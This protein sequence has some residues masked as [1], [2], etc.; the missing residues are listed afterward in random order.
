MLSTSDILQF[1]AQLEKTVQ[2]SNNSLKTGARLLSN[3]YLNY[4]KEKEQNAD[5]KAG[6]FKSMFDSF[7]GKPGF[8]SQAIHLIREDLINGEEKQ[9]LELLKDPETNLIEA[10]EAMHAHYPT[11]ISTK[12]YEILLSNL[13]SGRAQLKSITKSSMV[14][15]SVIVQLLLE[16]DIEVIKEVLLHIVRL[17]DI[18]SLI[19]PFS[20]KNGRGFQQLYDFITKPKQ[21]DRQ[22]KRLAIRVL[23]RFKP[24]FA[25]NHIY[26][27][28]PKVAR[29]LF[30]TLESEDREFD[31]Q[32][33]QALALCSS[34]CF[35]KNDMSDLECMLIGADVSLFQRYYTLLC[36]VA[37]SR[38]RNQNYFPQTSYPTLLIA[39]ICDNNAYP[40]NNETNRVFLLNLFLTTLIGL[41]YKKMQ[42]KQIP[43][44]AFLCL[45][46]FCV[47]NLRPHE[48]P[49]FIQIISVM[50][51]Y[52]NDPNIFFE[53][54]TVAFLLGYLKSAKYDN[55][56]FIG[57]TAFLGHISK[58]SHQTLTLCIKNKLYHQM[59][60]FW[61]NNQNNIDDE[62]L[63]GLLFESMHKFFYLDNLHSACSDEDTVDLMIDLL[64]SMPQLAVK[65]YMISY[66]TEALK[67]NTRTIQR[68]K[69]NV[70]EF[71]AY[72]IKNESS[73]NQIRMLDLISTYLKDGSD[74]LLFMDLDGYQT[75][76]TL[77]HDE[78]SVVVRAATMALS[79]LMFCKKLT[80]N[81]L[82]D[83]PLLYK[84]ENL[85]NDSPD[86]DTRHHATAVLASIN[87]ITPHY[88]QYKMPGFFGLK[89]R[90]GH[91]I[92][93]DQKRHF[94]RYTH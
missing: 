35:T 36:L 44:D 11:Q 56:I 39:T 4:L 63:Q 2:S 7:K 92:E 43:K 84:I 93:L 42:H 13:T 65:E 86:K 38:E 5:I 90:Q 41:I 52:N 32:V 81:L 80:H 30:D 54:G 74:A 69:K 37:K 16:S 23:V 66:L 12:T 8:N 77:L 9:H 46:R 18:T 91:S 14:K 70:F 27:Y 25:E 29:S 15:P 89:N 82:S 71:L 78:N 51:V 61:S 3:K 53:T 94:P 47:A 85:S 21:D 76:Q 68:R 1:F 10:V 60:I 17:N 83:I 28:S 72:W 40:A 87:R 64:P 31:E 62:V 45:L 55:E 26:I 49:S 73:D 58:A 6:Y 33:M 20:D 22:L 88:S 75:I 34:V 19:A 50:Y 59:L 57:I 48:I 24:H 79:K 67:Q